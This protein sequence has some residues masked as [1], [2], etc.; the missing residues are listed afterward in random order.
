MLKKRLFSAALAAA[1][2]FTLPACGKKD[3]PSQSA[4]SGSASS[5]FGDP[6][7]SSRSTGTAARSPLSKS[8]DRRRDLH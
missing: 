5:C 3:D 1:L 8:P 6:R 2:L 4:A 7:S